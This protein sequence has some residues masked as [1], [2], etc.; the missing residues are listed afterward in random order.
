MAY[1]AVDR[2]GSEAL[3]VE[4]PERSKSMWIGSPW[5]TLPAGSIKKLT[6]KELDWS[7]ECVEI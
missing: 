1:L 7:D 2:D 4:I 5:V 6:G 3:F